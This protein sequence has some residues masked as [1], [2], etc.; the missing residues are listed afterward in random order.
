M[1][2]NNNF[3]SRT[4]E[5]ERIQKVAKMIMY[6]VTPRDCLIINIDKVITKVESQINQ[7]SSS[8]KKAGG[9]RNRR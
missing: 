7:Q 6:D 2:V 9:D 5:A 4:T 8:S 3:S 1:T